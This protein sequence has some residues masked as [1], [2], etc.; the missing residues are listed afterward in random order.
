MIKRAIR[1]V[2][3]SRAAE[4]VVAIAL[5]WAVY[6][7]GWFAADGA[8]YFGGLGLGVLL[9]VAVSWIDDILFE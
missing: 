3:E 9:L 8:L 6:Q 1:A 5:F 2:L 4:S 7:T